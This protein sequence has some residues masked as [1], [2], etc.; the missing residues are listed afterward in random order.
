LA[1]LKDIA[2]RAG[3]SI[4]TVDRIIHKRGRYSSETAAKVREIME[5]VDYRPN[6]MARRLSKS[7]SC[8]IAAFLPWPEQDSGYWGLT[9]EGIRRAEGDLSPF[10]LNLDILHFNRYDADQFLQIGRRLAGG[11]FDGILMAPLRED[12]SRSLLRHIDKQIPVAFF[13]T[14][15]PGF[16]RMSYIG[17][18][19]Y[20]SGRL[21][22]RLMNLL[23][24]DN[25]GAGAL[26]LTPDTENEHLNR[27]FDGFRDV[28]NGSVR[29][30]RISI[31]SDHDKDALHRLLEREITGTLGLFVTDASAHYAAEYLAAE[32]GKAS[33]DFPRCFMVG[34]DLVDEN[35][36]WLEE[37][38]IDFLLT[39][40]PDEQGYDGVNRLFRKIVVDENP[41]EHIYTPIDIVTKENLRYHNVV[42]EGEYP[43]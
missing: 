10:G 11:Q 13:D 24:G 5:E 30:I 15:L 23:M 20:V 32:S 17:Q 40:R 7:K 18:D 26:V 36:R 37:G 39:Q 19:S 25:T 34:Y 6:L 38:T 21:A 42:N 16:P 2:D 14:D 28:F 41:P 8:R 3:V 4:G 1:T 12:E 27:R 33:G 43:L 35:R 22:G 31:E 29:S 9:L